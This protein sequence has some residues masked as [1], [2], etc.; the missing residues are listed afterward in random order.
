MLTLFNAGLSDSAILTL[1]PGFKNNKGLI[2]LDMRQNTF[3]NEGFKQFTA[4]I[5]G[6]KNL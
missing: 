4:S 6:L 3:E 2:Y 5:T 1:A